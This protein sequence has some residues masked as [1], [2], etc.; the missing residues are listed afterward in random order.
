MDSQD[1]KFWINDPCILIKNFELIP[2]IDYPFNKK[3]NILTRIII[4]LNFF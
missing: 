2:M 3:L 4:I 1:E